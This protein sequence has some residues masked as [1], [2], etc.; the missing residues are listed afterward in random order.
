MKHFHYKRYTE[1]ESVEVLRC[2]HAQHLVRAT[3]AE[4]NNS[5]DYTSTSLVVFDASLIFFCVFNQRLVLFAFFLNNSSLR[6]KI[7]RRGVSI[8][9]GPQQNKCLPSVSQV[10]LPSYCYAETCQLDVKCDPYNTTVQKLLT[11]TRSQP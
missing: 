3:T 8:K 7:I 9:W 10:S 1:I 11:I 4:P 6:R 2:E 5:D